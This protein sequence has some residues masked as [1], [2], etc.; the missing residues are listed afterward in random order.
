MCHIT[1]QATRDLPHRDSPG[2]L[3]YSQISYCSVMSSL[4]KHSTKRHSPAVTM[5]T[6]TN[7][8]AGSQ[9]SIANHTLHDR[10]SP[11]LVHACCAILSLLFQRVGFLVTLKIKM[12]NCK[13]ALGSALGKMSKALVLPA[14]WL[15]YDLAPGTFQGH[16]VKRGQ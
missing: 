1:F 16:K 15:H 7:L 9:A 2:R 12:V 11:R 3:Q 5:R 8:H 10:A 13:T 14:R 6:Q 4:G